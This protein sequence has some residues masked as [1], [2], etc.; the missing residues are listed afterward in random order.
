[1]SLGGQQ[2]ETVKEDV[3]GT[4]STRW[5]RERPHGATDLQEDALSRDLRGDERRAPG[6]QVGVTRELQVERLEPLRRLQ[7]QRGGIAVKKREEGDVGP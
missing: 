5:R 2:S 1:M 7:Q 3:K 6:G 4:G